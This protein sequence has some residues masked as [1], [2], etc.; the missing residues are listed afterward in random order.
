MT[1][2]LHLRCA[3]SVGFGLSVPNI[4]LGD[5]QESS[6]VCL[7]GMTGATRFRTVAAM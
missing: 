2:S 3:G 4:L 5:V 1:N 6:L 7:W